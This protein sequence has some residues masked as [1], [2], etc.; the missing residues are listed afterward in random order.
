MLKHQQQQKLTGG[1]AL[2][3]KPPVLTL[4]QRNDPFA[5]VRCQPSR[6]SHLYAGSRF[7]GKQ[8][9]GSSSYDVMV[10]IKDVN[11]KES[12]LCGYLH[13]NG[14]TEEYPELTT[15]F[16]AEIIGSAYSFKTEKW[17]AD[18]KTDKEHWALFDPYQ[19]MKDTFE[20]NP[21]Q[22][23]LQSQNVLFM[24]WKEHFL[25]PDHR[26]EGIPGASFEGFYYICYNKSTGDIEGYYYHKT[27][28]R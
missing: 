22:C 12:S 14:L 26:V 23:D 11:L 21:L 20:Q 8:K 6:T 3:R 18:E 24:R 25:V 27:S 9:S 2:L 13:I 15:F 16:D 17:G 1:L 10:D 4:S 28:E 7:R 19:S 5:P